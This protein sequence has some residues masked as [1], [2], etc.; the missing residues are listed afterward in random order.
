[1]TPTSYPIQY[2]E[3]KLYPHLIYSHSVVPATGHN[4]QNLVPEFL[5]IW[6]RQMTMTH[7]C[8][9]DFDQIIIEGIGK[10]T[11]RSDYGGVHP[12]SS[13]VYWKQHRYGNHWSIV[14]DKNDRNSQPSS[15]VCGVYVICRK[16]IAETEGKLRAELFIE[17]PAVPAS[18]IHEE[19]GRSGGRKNRCSWSR[20]IGNIPTCN[21]LHLKLGYNQAE[22]LFLK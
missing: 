19:F 13:R 21:I 20:S 10:L 11:I 9:K 4:W 3:K 17:Q 16:G 2:R 15:G 14:R 12:A 8:S 18:Q 7:G 6:K 1:M 5:E 22:Q